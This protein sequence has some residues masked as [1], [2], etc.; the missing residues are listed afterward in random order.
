MRVST[1]SIL[2]SFASPDGRETCN[3]PLEELPH[4]GVPVDEH[5]EDYDFDTAYVTRAAGDRRTVGSGRVILDFTHPDTGDSVG[6]LLS[7]ALCSGEPVDD[8]GCSYSLGESA[9]VDFTD[10][11]FA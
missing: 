4:S 9:D 7:D 11:K 5:G 1:S 3:M 8:Q 6:V 2:L 10:A